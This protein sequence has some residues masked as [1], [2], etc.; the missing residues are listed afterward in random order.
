MDT[1]AG[2]RSLVLGFS[3]LLLALPAF[4]SFEDVGFN[5]RSAA[6]GDAT[7]ALSDDLSSLASNP[8][9]LGQLRRPAVE[10]GIR[11]FFQQPAGTTDLSGMA[12]GAAVPLG[13]AHEGAL[14]LSFTHDGIERVALDRSVGVTYGTRGWREIGPGTL[15]GG[16]RFK[17]LGRAGRD[18]GGSV[19][20]AAVDLGTLFHWG[21]DRAVGLALLN[22][23]GPRTDLGALAD[24]APAMAKLG[25]VQNVRRFVVAMEVAQ[26]EASA[27][28]RSGTSAALGTEYGWGTARYGAFTGRSGVQLGGRVRTWNLGAGWRYLG[29]RLDYALRIPVSG[30]SR[31]GHAVSLTYRFGSWD[32]EAE[33]EKLLTSEMGYR[34]DLTRAL[35]AAEVKQ[36][37]LA[38]ELRL[39]RDELE[40]LR[41]ELALKAAE[42]GEAKGRLL[43]AQEQLRLKQLEER[44]RRAQAEFERLERERE[45]LHAAD[46]AGRFREDWSAYEG[47]KAQG[48]PEAVLIG[49]LQQL[50]RDY[51]GAGVDLGPA[52][53]ELQRLLRK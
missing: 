29:A 27:G 42:S 39:L 3:G 14:G 49:R 46:K 25:F 1:R 10:A 17:F 24:R 28:Y 32:P 9:G 30:D 11:R 26:R 38:E 8:A 43:Q 23:N 35:E 40:Q 2:K 34:Q 53:Q 44:R 22:L 37:K 31:W 52:H 6:M 47:L 51:R 33:Y 41:R 7:A 18:F 21:D 36:W 50:L 20:R 45:R 4:A 19:S 12:V 5:A 13:P 15:E 48:A 16:V